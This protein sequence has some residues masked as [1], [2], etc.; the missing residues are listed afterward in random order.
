V[1]AN[2]SLDSMRIRFEQLDGQA[3]WTS[4]F[5]DPKFVG[6]WPKLSSAHCHE[7]AVQDIPQAKSSLRSFLGQHDDL[8]SLHLQ[9]YT[10]Q[11]LHLDLS[12]VFQGLSAG[13]L[14]SLTTL[15]LPGD[16]M[17]EALRFFSPKPQLLRVR[18]L[19]R[20]LASEQLAHIV[21]QLAL[22]THLKSLSISL[23]HI[24][25]DWSFIPHLE[26]LPGALL[27]L[28][29]LQ[30]GSMN[31]DEDRHVDTRQLVS[32]S[33]AQ[34]PCRRVCSDQT[35]PPTFEFPQLGK[36][37]PTEPEMHRCERGQKTWQYILELV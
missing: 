30:I 1:F 10:L 12:A 19:Y 18:I 29:S 26:P 2:P 22:Q 8:Q 36:R 24:P 16:A 27:F 33:S 4:L 17:L 5:V 35:C 21:P 23:V 9:L 32:S 37:H 7:L 34:P 13:S 11:G 20:T 3:D 6:A 31:H 14:T 28:R 25:E 15:E